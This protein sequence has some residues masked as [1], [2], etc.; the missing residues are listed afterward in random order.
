M[1]LNIPATVRLMIHAL[2]A[3]LIMT[4]SPAGLAQDSSVLG[5]WEISR[6]LMTGGM[7]PQWS[8]REDDPRLLGRHLSVAADGM[9]FRNTETG[10]VLRPLAGGKTQSIRSLFARSGGK[11]P[12]GMRGT[13][14]GR[15]E[16][17]ELGGLHGR[18]VK[19]FQIHCRAGS[20][21]F[22][23]DANWLATTTSPATLLIPYEPDALLVLR[24]RPAPGSTPDAGQTEYCR[25]ANSPSDRAICAD[26][27]LW[28]MHSYTISAEQRA[29]SPR[30]ELNAE[31]AREIADQ[32]A[33][34]Q[35]CNGETNCLYEV[36][37]QHIELL[38]QRW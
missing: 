19:L 15:Q 8:M 21:S 17:Y 13:L 33:K 16:D 35:A 18:A 37:D 30:P 32:L 29:Q 7:Q 3:T 23:D 12:A 22:L 31:L 4:G 10:C 6:V 11:R 24:R 27:Q 1:A 2:L 26:R 36:L 38:V 14:Y 9:Q 20:E 28:Q 25:Q 5:D 34:R